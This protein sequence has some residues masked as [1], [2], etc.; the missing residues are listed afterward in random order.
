MTLLATATAGIKLSKTC[1][2]LEKTNSGQS[3]DLLVR[4]VF[5]MAKIR[6]IGHDHEA[7]FWHV[8]VEVFSGDA[9]RK[10]TATCTIHFGPR[11][12]LQILDPL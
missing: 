1:M 6:R 5:A 11:I 8:L 10:Q 2:L 3:E 7:P 9:K 12:F 4:E